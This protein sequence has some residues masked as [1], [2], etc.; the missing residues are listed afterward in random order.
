[1]RG[2]PSVLGVFVFLGCLVVAFLFGSLGMTADMS[3]GWD[4]FYLTV[5]SWGF[6][7][8]IAI[9]SLYLAV[10][11][12][13]GQFFAAWLGVSIVAAMIVQWIATS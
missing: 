2:L 12:G 13:R 6:L 5:V 3:T 11:R 8:P 7:S 9:G 10:G 1:M 4:W